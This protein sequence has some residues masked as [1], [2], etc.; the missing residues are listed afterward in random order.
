MQTFDDGGGV[1]EVASTQGAD[2]VGVE[3][4]QQR[5][6]ALHLRKQASNKAQNSNTKFI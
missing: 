1:Y 3:V 4:P 6:A 2:E 5:T